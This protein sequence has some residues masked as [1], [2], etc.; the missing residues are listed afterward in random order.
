MLL[1]AQDKAF[2]LVAAILAMVH[3]VTMLVH[4]P[5]LRNGMLGVQQGWPCE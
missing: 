2:G 4:G 5:A 1:R 3:A